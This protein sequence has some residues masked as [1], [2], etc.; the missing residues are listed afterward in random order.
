MKLQTDKKRTF[1]VKEVQN[2]HTNEYTIILNPNENTVR[3]KTQFLDYGKWYYS[4][5]EHSLAVLRPPAAGEKPKALTALYRIIRGL[6][7]VHLYKDKIKY[8]HAKQ[9]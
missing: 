7:D 9:A 4:D 2:R 8:D 6:E 5:L 1:I 3:V